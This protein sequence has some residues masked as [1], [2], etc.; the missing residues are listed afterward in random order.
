MATEP[1]RQYSK[2]RKVNTLVKLKLRIERKQRDLAPLVNDCII[3]LGKLSGGQMSEYS[4]IMA[5][6]AEG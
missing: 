4:R 2:S 1:S 5:G 6:L 3:R